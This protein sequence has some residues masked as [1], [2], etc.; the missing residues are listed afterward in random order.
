MKYRIIKRLSREG[1]KYYLV[2][3]Y[4]KLELNW[5]TVQ[6]Y[7][8]SDLLFPYDDKKFGTVKKAK[9]YIKKQINEAKKLRHT[10]NSSL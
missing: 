8:R 3:K 1:D 6:Q 2:Q 9:K 10:S 5:K 4:N 7:N